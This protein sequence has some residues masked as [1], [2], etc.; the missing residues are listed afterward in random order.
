M[1]TKNWTLNVIVFNPFL[2]YLLE[3]KWLTHGIKF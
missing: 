3:R 1:N 2:F